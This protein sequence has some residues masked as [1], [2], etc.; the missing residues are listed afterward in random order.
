[1]AEQ[2]DIFIETLPLGRNREQF[3]GVSLSPRL[4]ELSNFVSPPAEPG[5]YPCELWNCFH[6]GA[7]ATQTPFTEG[8]DTADLQEAKALLA[9]LS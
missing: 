8:F 5:A 9:S 4:P 1:M 2:G 6:N 7:V 3:T